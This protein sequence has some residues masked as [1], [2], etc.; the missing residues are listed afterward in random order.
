M[1][2]QVAHPC[3]T[4]SDLD[5]SEAF[6]VDKLGLARAFDFINNEGRRFGVY[7]NAG[8]RT[9]IE[10]FAGELAAPAEKQAYKHLC[11]EVDDMD[12]TLADLRANGVEVTGHKTGSDHSIQAWI[13]DPD[14][15][16]IE[17]MQYTPDSKQGP[18]LT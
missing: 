16:R 17:L 10:L 11:L 14:G 4:V 5:A 13:T 9:F 3:Y 7:L 2:K 8:N 18:W 12:T 1:I 6:Y 15:N